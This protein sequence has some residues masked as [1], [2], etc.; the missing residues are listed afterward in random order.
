MGDYFDTKEIT[1]RDYLKIIFRHK[2]KIVATF[3][4]LTVLVFIGLQLMTPVFQADVK[5]L[6]SGEKQTE[7]PYYRG[8]MGYTGSQ[9]ALT[10][11]EIV[12]SNPVIERAVR[13]L[14]LDERPRDYEKQFCSALKAPLVDLRIKLFDTIT[15]VLNP[16]F[17]RLPAEQKQAYYFLQAVKD[18][19]EGIEV[20]PVMESNVF[21]ISASDFS[22][23]GAAVTAN[24]VSRSYVIYDLEQQLA[25][26]QLKYGEKHLAVI[27]LRD[28]IEKMTKSL[29][30]EPLYNNV[31]AIGP[32][33]VKIIEQA[34]LPLEPKYSTLLLLILAVFM[35]GFFAVVSAFIFEYTDQTVKSPQ[36]IER[37]LN[38]PFLGSIPKVKPK[39]KALSE[40]AK[41][42][43]NYAQAYRRVSE[44][45]YLL[46]KDK[47]LKSLLIT[48]ALESEGA[49]SIIANLGFCLSRDLGHKVIIID[50]NLRRPAAHEIF[51]MQ[52]GPGLAGI[53]EGGI[54]FEKA[55][56][57]IGP[58]L[59]IL[60][61]G[62][63]ALNPIILLD[64]AKF[65]EV[66]RLAKERYEIALF[67]CAELNDFKDSVVISKYLDSVAIVVNEGRTR[68]Q[69]INNAIDLLRRQKANLI[70]AI[71]NNRVYAV[72]KMIYERV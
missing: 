59:S 24:V 50:A 40:K 33:S 26:L 48:S 16:E 61:A 9:M 18:L 17:D 51:D 63:T 34:S 11:S 57:E 56:K 44:Q 29:T 5:M 52:D 13:V 68:Y 8:L 23:V 70:G 12:K 42:K 38:L 10:Q 55:V 66:V 31:E 46:L 45:I 58:G 15:K 41:P 30:G 65:S 54:T 72:P 69:V 43:D 64:S 1:F 62:K 21:T 2:L 39:D 19:K 37:A 7:S 32:A 49:T 20:E 47:N 35:N 27:Q 28:S 22:P 67:D 14:R 6:I 36:D 25:D 60:P 71:L 4:I 53:L 3:I